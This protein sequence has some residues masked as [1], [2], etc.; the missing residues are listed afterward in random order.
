MLSHV[1]IEREVYGIS[2]GTFF[3]WVDFHKDRILITGRKDIRD[4]LAVEINKP[5]D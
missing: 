1:W 5:V 3:M 4:S 2:K